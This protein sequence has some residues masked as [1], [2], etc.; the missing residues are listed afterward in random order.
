MEHIDR[1]EVLLGSGA[2]SGALLLGRGFA[3]AAETREQLIPWVDQ[4][5]PVPPPAQAVVKTLTPWENLD[6]WITPDDKFFGVG[7]Y[8]WPAIDAARRRLDV[9]GQV[10]LPHTYTLNDL[11]ARP[12]Q[13][14]TF[15]LECSGDNG[16]PFL[17]SAM[18]TQ[19]GPAPGSP[20]FLRRRRPRGARRKWCSWRRPGR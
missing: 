18:A 6:S 12:R 19:N 16:L 17:T 13:E 3:S 14:V 1:R 4:P 10:D 9:V 20:T 11:K 8:E 7:L 2:A 5:P 15:T